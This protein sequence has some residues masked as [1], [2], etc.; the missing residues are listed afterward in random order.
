VAKI[1]LIL[2]VHDKGG[3]MPAE[4]LEHELQQILSHKAMMATRWSVEKVTSIRK[5]ESRKSCM[6]TWV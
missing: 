4:L 5:M 6:E 2:L 3:E 1:T